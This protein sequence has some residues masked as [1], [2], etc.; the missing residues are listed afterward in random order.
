MAK[1]LSPS[2]KKRLLIRYKQNENRNYHT[3]NAMMLIKIF[4]TASEKAKSRKLKKQI[5]SRGY[6]T[7]EESHWFTNHG[8]IHYYKL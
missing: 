7:M 4:G 6:V 2:E 1:K 3:E 5:N 8:H